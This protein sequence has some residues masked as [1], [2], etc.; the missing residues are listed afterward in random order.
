MLRLW[1]R[2]HEACPAATLSIYGDGPEREALETQRTPA[3]HFCGATD[4]VAAVY[5]EADLLLL[6]SRTE[7]FPLVLVEAQTAGVPAVAFDCPNGPRDIITDGEN[8][9]LIPYH[10]DDAF[11]RA[12]VALLND[13]PARR[14][15][16][17]AATQA[18]ARWQP[19]NI[20]NKWLQ[21]F[22]TI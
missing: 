3:A 11:V 4:D 20:M 10:D 7:C 16:A 6:T 1:R 15:M 12:V 13:P 22:D 9:R 17:Q 19:E 8:G 18:A 5:A 21:L 14:A 2:V